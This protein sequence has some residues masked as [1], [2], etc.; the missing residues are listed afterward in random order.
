MFHDMICFGYW[1]H[2]GVFSFLESKPSSSSKRGFFWVYEGEQW[3]RKGRMLRA[4]VGPR[5]G[6]A[7]GRRILLASMPS[8]K[9]GIL[10]LEKD[11]KTRG[12]GWCSGV[13][14]ARP[15]RVGA[16]A[17]LQT[18]AFSRDPR[19][20]TR[21]VWALT[22]VCVILTLLLLSPTDPV[23]DLVGISLCCYHPIVASQGMYGVYPL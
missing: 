6:G 11:A 15:P 21:G 10:P 19:G 7:A 13:P 18:P 12:H 14:A 4:R 9:D 16:A 23:F 17:W 20:F 3:E 5:V 8:I 2:F 22:K 1:R